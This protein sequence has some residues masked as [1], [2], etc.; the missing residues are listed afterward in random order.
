MVAMSRWGH[1]NYPGAVSSK[2][3][4]FGGSRRLNPQR[5]IVLMVN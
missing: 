3:V 4:R 1:T 2:L 5:P